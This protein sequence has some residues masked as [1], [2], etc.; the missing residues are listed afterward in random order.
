MS[1][2][3]ADFCPGLGID[4]NKLPARAQSVLLTAAGNVVRETAIQLTRT[5][6]FQ[7]ERIRDSDSPDAMLS[8]RDSPLQLAP[9][10]ESAIYRLLDAPSD[11]KLNGADAL[12]DAFEQIRDHHLA[13]DDAIAAAINELLSRPSKSLGRPR[14]SSVV[15]AFCR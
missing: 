7:A 13:F 1:N 2:A 8:E 5:L 6:K 9:S 14:R 4:P 10:V 11:S 12:R 15:I 3:L